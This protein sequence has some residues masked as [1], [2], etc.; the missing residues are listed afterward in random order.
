MPNTAY[1]YYSD[2]KSSCQ[3]PSWRRCEPSSEANP[4]EAKCSLKKQKQKN[5]KFLIC[6]FDNDQSRPGI[7]NR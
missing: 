7:L 5:K 3:I 1:L 4:G 6:L 2:P